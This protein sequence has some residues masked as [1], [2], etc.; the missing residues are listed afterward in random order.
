MIFNSLFKLLK[1]YSKMLLKRER[2][3]RFKKVYTGNLI[4]ECSDKIDRLDTR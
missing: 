1:L 3:R 4:R 2:F